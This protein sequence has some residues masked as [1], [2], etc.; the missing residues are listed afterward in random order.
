MTISHFGHNDLDALGCMLNLHA[1]YP[2]AK[3]E[4]FHTNYRNLYDQVH[5]CIDFNRKHTPDLLVIADVS[6]ATERELLKELIDSMQGRRVVYLDHHMY[7]EG[8]FDGLEIEHVHDLDRSATQITHDFFNIDHPVLNAMTTLIDVYD[9]WR[10]KS[11]LF[12]KALEL[13]QY[14]WTVDIDWLA[15]EMISNGYKLPHNYQEVVK[16]LNSKAKKEIKGYYDRGLIHT[17]DVTTIAFVD[18]YFNQILMQE[19]NRGVKFLIIA[20]SYGIIRVRINQ[21]AGI[22]DSVKHK[23][24]KAILQDENIG[25]MNAF[26]YKLEHNSFENIM[27]EIQRISEVLRTS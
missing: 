24:K 16:N 17:N 14:F 25:H 3:T 13:N 8:F 2:K 11:P 26:A 6:F 7:P 18:D 12:T 19:F 23:I 9:I 22:P 15:H 27:K 20:N 4:T 1:A 10:I 5:K 21:Y